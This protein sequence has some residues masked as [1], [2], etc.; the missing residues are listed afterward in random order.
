MQRLEIHLLQPRKGVLHGSCSHYAVTSSGAAK[1]MVRRPVPAIPLEILPLGLWPRKNPLQPSNVLCHL[2]ALGSELLAHFVLRYRP[3]PFFARRYLL[4]S[5]GTSDLQLFFLF[6]IFNDYL[7][8]DNCLFATCV[9]S[10]LSLLRFT[11]A[12]LCFR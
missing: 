9:P 3:D 6:F 8:D 10:S 7:R 2:R 11:I 12:T 5:R 1:E 4:V